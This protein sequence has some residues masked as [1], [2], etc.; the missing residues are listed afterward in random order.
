MAIYLVDMENIPHA[1][2]K[3]L[4]ACTDRDR[5]VLFYTEQVSQVPITLMEKVTGSPAA[6]EYIRCRGGTNGLDFQLVTEMGYRVARDPSAEYIIVS[7]DHGFDVVVDY[8]N[9]RGVPT[10]RIVPSVSGQGG[11][12]SEYGAGGEG[13]LQEFDFSD[14]Q[15]MKEFLSWRLSNKV[16]KTEIPFIVDILMDAMVQGGDYPCDKRLSYRFTYLDKA[17][18]GK[19]GDAKGPKL[20]DQ[21]K[22]V[23]REA[24]SLSLRTE[25]E[26]APEAAEPAEPEELVDVV[27]A[28]LAALGITASKAREAA[29][30]VSEVLRSGEE[31]QRAA[32]YRRILSTFGRKD[33]TELYRAAK[34]SV[35]QLILEQE[36]YR[37]GS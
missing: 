28:R 17:L 26:D 2:G 20:R 3:L 33:G 27:Y 5:F 7:Q 19:Y 31:H 10:R 9:E 15:S 30:I 21:I 8:W 14:P 4:D 1:W 11:A 6:V 35:G 24:F 18:R 36:A 32:I 12:I 37:Q 23:S 13:E 29:G 16:R 22:A 34:D 25:T